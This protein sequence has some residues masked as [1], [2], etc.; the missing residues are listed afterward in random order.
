FYLRRD[1]EN[2]LPFENGG[3]VQLERALYGGS[4]QYNGRRQLLGR[5]YRIAAGLTIEQQEDLRRRYDNLSG[6]LGE[7]AFDQ[8]EQFT[9]LGAYVAQEWSPTERLWLNAS[10]RYDF[11]A[12]SADD[13]FT[14]DGDNSGE[15]AYHTLSP[16]LGLSYAWRTRHFLYANYSYSFETPALSELSAGT[17]GAGGFNEALQPQRA[18]NFEW[19]GKGKAGSVQYNLSLFYIRLRGELLPFEQAGQNGRV[20]FRNAGRSRRLGVEVDGEWAFSDRWCLFARYNYA[21]FSY[22]DYEL[23]GQNYSGNQ[24]PGI[25]AHNGL[26]ALSFDYHPRG[27]ITLQGRSLSQIWADDANTV[28]A[29]AFGV[30]GLRAAQSWP[31]GNSKLQLFGG[32]N[33]LFD[34]RYNQNV[35]VN[36]FGGR[37]FEPAPGRNAYFGLS[38]GLQ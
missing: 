17:G 25:P 7:L 9:A 23:Q 26:I 16:A 5:P 8:L 38:L 37:Y 34:V 6:E 24:L 12:L 30:V 33:N 22:L 14:A 21:R 18:Y 1:F 36:A 4:F 35:R 27:E 2:R 19:G 20:L 11:N 15:R 29:D 10:L 28:A 13:Y 32:V 3:A 31:W